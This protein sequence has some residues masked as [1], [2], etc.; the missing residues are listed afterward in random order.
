MEYRIAL[1]QVAPRLGDVD[2]NLAIAADAV[3]RAAIEGATL[4][5]L[6]ELALTGYLL[7]DLVPEVSMRADDPRL[8]SVGDD[9]PRMLVAAGFVEE[10]DDHRYCNSAAL[11][12]DGALVG[13]HRK[14]YLPTYGLF[15]EG[16]FTR[17]GDRIRTVGVGEPIGRI[18][19][20]VCEDFWHPSVPMI[21][22]Q[23]GAD[24]LV[25]ISAGPS[26]APGSSAGLEAIAGWHK[27]QDTY[28]L[29]GTVAIAFC[30]RVGN[31]EGLTFW[32][33]SRIIGPGGSTVAQAPLWDEALVVGAIDTDDVRMQRYG[34]P[35]LADE[36]L[37]LVR[38]EL[39]R[40]IAERA[41]LDGVPERES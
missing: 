14:V 9:A 4:T 22:A 33:G 19:V 17:P 39:D 20:S 29:L 10:T 36:R 21:Q 37:E 30:N 26:R 41:G 31:E 11:V 16:R 25:N 13:L 28:A 27:M 32:G 34:M 15:D 12:R 35:L 7:Q 2:A 3:R 40:I 24:L 1:A 23:D 5:V 18:G 8:L 6:P 38:R